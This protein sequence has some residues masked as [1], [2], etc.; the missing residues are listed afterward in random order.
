MTT[1]NSLTAIN[2]TYPAQITPDEGGFFTVKFR[3]VPFAITDGSTMA[4]AIEE[5]VDCLSE[6]LAS[7]IEDNEA[8]PLP[9]IPLE[10]EVMVSPSALIAAK[11]ALYLAAREQGIS[12]TSLAGRLGVSE[13]VGRRL[14]DPHHQTKLVKIDEALHAMGKRM[15]IG[16]A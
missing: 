16:L 9:S 13:A 8:I 1:T 7:C 2:F 15:V 10:G 3:D 11:A 12:K 5:A 6:A 4:E 14:L